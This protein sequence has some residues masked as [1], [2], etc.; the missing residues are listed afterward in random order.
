M[1]ERAIDAAGRPGPSTVDEPAPA[2]E[3]RRITG[4]PELRPGDDLA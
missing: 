3:I 4:I 2:I 1:A